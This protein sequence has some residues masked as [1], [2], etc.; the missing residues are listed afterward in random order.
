MT[1]NRTLATLRRRLAL[2]E[3]DLLRQVCAEQAERIAT[4]EAELDRTRG[5]FHSAVDV[6]EQWREN[7]MD[8]QEQILNEHP[9]YQPGI[10]QSG[11]LGIVHATH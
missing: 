10:T 2:A 1:T 4:L 11:A 9:A 8:L 6:S 7:F 3:L 5:L